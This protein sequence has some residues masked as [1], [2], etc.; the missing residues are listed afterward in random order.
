MIKQIQTKQLRVGMYIEKLGGS[1]IQHPFLR[2]SFL[3]TNPDDIKR[4]LQAGIRD[5]WIDES[6]SEIGLDED[7]PL[8]A[9]TEQQI[10]A[11][12]TASS[13]K[14][15]VK[16]KQE[17][18][19]MDADIELARKIC[20]SGK[21]QVM[22]MFQDV[23]L[24]KAIDPESTLPL[25][26]QIDALVQNNSA[27]ILSV[28]R[29]KTHDDYTYMHSI[30]VCAL[31]ISLARQL[32]LDDDM[33]RLAGIGGMMHDLGKAL[34]PIDILNKPGKL[35]D[36]EYDIMKAHPKAGADMLK[37]SDAEAAVIDIALHHHE[38]M[39][40]FG[41]PNQLKGED[42]SLLSRMAAICDVYDAVTSERAYKKPWEPANTIRLMASWEGHFDK[43]IFNAFVKS[44]GIY[45]VGSLVRLTSQHLA[46][47]TE[48][49]PDLLLKPKVKIFFSLKSK[50][51]VPLKVIDLA[52][53][54]CKDSIEGPEE[55]ADWNFKSL[56][57]LWM[58]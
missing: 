8:L 38:K 40:G 13:D 52:A 30:A 41:Y 35:T 50:A 42:I 39:N 1:W 34:M 15:Q 58:L 28:A 22:A 37:E 49:T 57:D 53:H 17:P 10:S 54:S 29:L 43:H 14:Q 51:P 45:P 24:G 55:R 5:V 26:Q 6:K 18:R 21:K 9:K 44:I 4:I 31:M 46:V 2:S 36:A 12:A 47:V 33:I 25:V 19:S 23:R 27:A 32:E 20:H 11:E 16:K 7:Q 48:P 3:V 56:D